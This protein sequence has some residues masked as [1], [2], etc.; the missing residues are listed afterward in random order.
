MTTK[1]KI[2]KTQSVHLRLDIG[3]DLFLQFKDREEYFPSYLI[4]LKP[5]AYIIIKTPAI[6]GEEYG[7]TKERQVILKY[8]HLGE[9]FR[10][11]ANV[12]ES[13][14]K[15][16][17]ITF[18]TFP[19]QIEKIEFRNS[20]RVFCSIP[21]N[22]YFKDNEVQGAVTDISIGG[23]RFKT[24]DIN[25]FEEIILIKRDEE[26]TLHFALLGLEEIK[27]FSCTV[28]KIG[29]DDDITLRIGF[30]EIDTEFSDMIASYVET[31]SE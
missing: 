22:L 4:G 2:K 19:E 8:K 21:A 9:V 3:S 6:L 27:E 31:T 16:F 24:K 7:L 26:V 23:C 11:N 13:L 28:K 18:I 29:F 1:K 14:D 10:F 12:I 25:K 17:K 15:P 20:S 5:D 30:K